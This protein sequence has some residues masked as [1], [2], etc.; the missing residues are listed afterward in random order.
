MKLGTEASRILFKIL[1]QIYA[2]LESISFQE[3]NKVRFYWLL[4][5]HTCQFQQKKKKQKQKKSSGL[6]SGK[7]PQHQIPPCHPQCLLSAGKELFQVWVEFYL[8]QRPHLKFII[9]YPHYNH[10]FNGEFI[11]GLRINCLTNEIRQTW[12][13]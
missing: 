12:C 9:T 13:V 7:F 3:V 4:E 1:M 2:V 8:V 5:F 10:H 11:N 6:T